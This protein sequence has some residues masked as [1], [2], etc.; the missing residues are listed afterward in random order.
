MCSGV[1]PAAHLRRTASAVWTRTGVGPNLADHVDLMFNQRM[2]SIETLGHFAAR[3]AWMVAGSS[4]MRHRRGMPSSNVA[5]AGGFFVAGQRS[6]PDLQ[7]DF[8]SAIDDYDKRWRHSG[9]GHSL[10]ACVLRP[11]SRGA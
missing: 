5:E 4:I 3:Q 9:H 10:H 11:H 7:L 8:C 1:G 2:T 6:R